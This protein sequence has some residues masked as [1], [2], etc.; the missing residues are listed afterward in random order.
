MGEK[1]EVMEPIGL[2]EEIRK[3]L[4]AAINRYK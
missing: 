3:R 1:I 4:F 2:R